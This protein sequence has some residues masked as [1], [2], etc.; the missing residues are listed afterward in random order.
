M[1][2]KILSLLSVLVVLCTIAPLVR[3]EDQ[4]VFG[5]SDFE[6]GSLHLHRI[7]QRFCQILCLLFI[8]RKTRFRNTQQTRKKRY[9]EKK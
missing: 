7:P 9:N 8:F 4:T 6:I 3:A 5:P 1:S 2:R